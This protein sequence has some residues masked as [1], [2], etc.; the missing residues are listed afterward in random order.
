MNDANSSEGSSARSPV[1]VPAAIVVAGALIAA[2]LYFSGG[3][4]PSAPTKVGGEPVVQKGDSAQAADA[5]VGD[6][7]PVTNED[8]IRGADNAK[9][10]IVE[11]SDIECPFCKR[12]HSTMQQ[13]IGEYPDDV[14]WVYRHYPLKQLHSK[15]PKEAEAT[16]CAAEQG[17][18]W[19]MIDLIFKV[20]PSNN[21]L[22]LEQLPVLADQAGVSNVQ[23]FKE[24]LESGKY[25]DKVAAD[26][27][28]GTVAGVQGTPYSVII[29]SDGSKIPLSGAQ[30]Y[31]S[32]K[33]AVEKLL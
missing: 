3:R 32:L 14:R 15:A 5:V 4:V 13:L 28:D 19:E 2:A 33:A 10:T 29:G 11:Y 12:F 1:G 30:P 31:T 9:V 17:K 20:T 24:C 23:Q 26:S 25:A 8:H 18:F 7:R 27:A 6:I 16:E 22:D 21:G